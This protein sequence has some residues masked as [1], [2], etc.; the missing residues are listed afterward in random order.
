MSLTQNVAFYVTGEWLWIDRTAGRER[1]VGG[2]S[3]CV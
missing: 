1:W 3:E 2:G